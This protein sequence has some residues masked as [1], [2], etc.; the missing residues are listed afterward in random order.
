MDRNEDRFR[1]AQAQRDFFKKLTPDT[2][3]EASVRTFERA[4]ARCK[5]NGKRLHP[6]GIFWEDVNDVQP[7]LPIQN[8]S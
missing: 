4:K 1:A 2:S 7:M 5:R 3:P 8:P 6:R